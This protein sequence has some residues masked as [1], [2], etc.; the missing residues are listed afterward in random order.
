M[1]KRKRKDIEAHHVAGRRIALGID[2]ALT[3]CGMAA[4]DLDECRI[5]AVATHTFF[6]CLLTTRFIRDD[7]SYL[8]VYVE[9]PAVHGFLYGRWEKLIAQRM[10][11]G[12]IQKEMA[13][14]ET[15][16]LRIGMNLGAS[17]LLITALTEKEFRVYPVKPT[18]QKLNASSFYNITRFEGTTNQNE[19]DAAMLVFGKQIGDR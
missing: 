12:K 13:I 17:R 4:Y 9:N 16:L 2:P 19:R 14:V 8:A 5:L 15:M 1:S 11:A 3:L 18:K 7:A 6:K 10:D